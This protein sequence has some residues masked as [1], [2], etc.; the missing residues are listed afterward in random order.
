[1]N[2]HTEIHTISDGE[3]ITKESMFPRVTYARSTPESLLSFSS[4]EHLKLTIL[5]SQCPQQ[6][7]YDRNTQAP[8]IATL[9]DGTLTRYLPLILSARGHEKGHMLVFHTCTFSFINP[10]TLHSP[11]WSQLLPVC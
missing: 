4:P 8:L 7:R 9:Q 6:H 10:V 3:Y 11:P 5:R 1:M 2:M